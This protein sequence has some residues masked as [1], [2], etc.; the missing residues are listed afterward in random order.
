MAYNIGE[1]LGKGIYCSKQCGW[2]VV[3]DDDD[4][5]LPPCGNCGPGRSTSYTRW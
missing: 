1:K 5:R 4:D 2:R 3:L